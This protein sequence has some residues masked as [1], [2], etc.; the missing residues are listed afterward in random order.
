MPYLK[1]IKHYY[2]KCKP[3]IVEACKYSDLNQ[4]NEN[5]KSWSPKVGWNEL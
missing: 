4:D 2:H 3:N 1:D 5:P